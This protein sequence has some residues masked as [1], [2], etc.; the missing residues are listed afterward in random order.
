VNGRDGPQQDSGIAFPRGR[1][2]SRPGRALNWKLRGRHLGLQLF[3][4]RLDQ[5]FLQW[6][7]M[8]R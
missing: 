3:D 1:V 2:G 8:P 4:Y 7:E 5:F 6:R